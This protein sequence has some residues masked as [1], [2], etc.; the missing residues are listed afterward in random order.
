VLANINRFARLNHYQTAATIGQLIEKLAS[1]PD[2]DG[3]MLDH[4]MVMYGRGMSI[5][6]Q[7]DHDPLPMLLAGGASVRLR[8]WRHIRMPDGTPAANLLLAVLNKLN[9]PLESF[10]DS[11][12]A[13][14]I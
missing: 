9:V 1:T 4:S 12:G 6:N 11:T 13:V 5:P 3:S 2:G 7:H 8:G 10:A 14:E